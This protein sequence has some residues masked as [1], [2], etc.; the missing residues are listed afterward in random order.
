MRWFV[1]IFVVAM[2]FI[3]AYAVSDVAYNIATWHSSFNF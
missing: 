3:T 1:L 2:V